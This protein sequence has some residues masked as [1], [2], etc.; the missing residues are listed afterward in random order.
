MAELL[1]STWGKKTKTKNTLIHTHI[2]TTVGLRALC[3]LRAVA[4]LT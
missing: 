3:V 1:S 2:N 4:A